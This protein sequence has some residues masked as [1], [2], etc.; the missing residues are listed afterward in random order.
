MFQPI[1][2]I[3]NSFAYTFLA[4]LI[5]CERS[6]SKEKKSN[7]LF[8]SSFCCYLGITFTT[9]G[10]F[11]MI[12]NWC[13]CRGTKVHISPGKNEK[14]CKVLRKKFLWES[15]SFHIQ[16]KV[17]NL[18]SQL[19]IHFEQYYRRHPSFQESEYKR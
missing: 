17:V 9:L 18:P 5:F 14:D 15:R 3:T 13:Y 16:K 7:F 2:S 6:L 10:N 1:L 4:L 19:H 11:P 8:E 12:T